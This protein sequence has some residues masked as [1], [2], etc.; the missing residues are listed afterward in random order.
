[1]N[2]FG[3]AERLCS[4]ALMDRLHAEGRRTMAFPF[5]VR[6]LWVD[7]L[8]GQVPCQVLIVAPKRRLHRAVDRNRVKRLVRECYRLRKSALYEAIGSRGGHLVLA[9]HY[10]HSEVMTFEQMSRK[11]DRFFPQLVSAIC[12]EPLAD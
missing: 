3:K 1:M 2:T 8:P 12:S 10:V 4:R 7:S 9:L 5:S 6:W 11:F